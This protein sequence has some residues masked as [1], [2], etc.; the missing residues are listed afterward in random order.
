M[1]MS[2]AKSEPYYIY[3]LQLEGSR[4]YVGSTK[5]IEK[6]MRTHFS[7]GGAI[8]TKECCPIS[9]HAIYRLVDY[10]IRTDCAHERAEVMVATRLAEIVGKDK[11]RGAKHGK[12]WSDVPSPNNL[13]DIER[14][15]SFARTP[16]GIKLMASLELLPIDEVI[17]ERNQK[18]LATFRIRRTQTLSTS[19]DQLLRQDFVDAD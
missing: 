15:R 18:L 4:W 3:V 14:Y 13:R 17:D 12:G 7:H 10:Q 16:D 19:K 8:A 2:V 9:I 11:V 1:G 5:T 6:R